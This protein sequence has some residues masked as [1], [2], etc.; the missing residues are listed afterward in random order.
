MQQI[1][2]RPRFGLNTTGGTRRDHFL[3]CDNELRKLGTNT[4][5]WPESHWQRERKRGGNGGRGNAYAAVV[6]MNRT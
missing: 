5:W 4:S 1:I 3:R 6:G 2:H